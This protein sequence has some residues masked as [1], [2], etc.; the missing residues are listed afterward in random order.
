MLIKCPECGKE[1]SDKASQCIHCGFPF[2]EEKSTTIA[3]QEVPTIPSVPE[4]PFRYVS[5]SGGNISVKCE[6][7]QHTSKHPM[8]GFTSISS[9]GCE[10]KTSLQC[11]NCTNHAPAGYK[12]INIKASIEHNKKMNAAEAGKELKCPRCG[13]TQIATVNRGYN[14][15]TGFMGSGSARNICQKC[16]FRWKPGSF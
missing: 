5:F 9:T 2:K 3:I 11:P 10:V 15:V 13:A 12:L 14:I 6:K 1:V 7:C 4:E 8:D 16:G